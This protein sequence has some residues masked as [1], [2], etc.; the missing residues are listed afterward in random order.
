M[1]KI[2]ITLATFCMLQ[3]LKAQD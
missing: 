3:Q 1:K 2:F